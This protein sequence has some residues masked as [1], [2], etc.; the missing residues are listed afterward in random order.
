MRIPKLILLLLFIS[1]AGNAYSQL[2][3]LSQ[4]DDLSRILIEKLR[5][6][7]S[8]KIFVQTDRTFYN[9]GEKIWFKVYCLNSLSGRPVYHPKTLYIDLV[10]EKDSCAARLLLHNE[11]GST[12]GYI[13][14]P[15]SI[16]SGYYLIRGYSKKVLQSNIN[17]IFTVPVY[18]YNSFKSEE[19]KSGRNQ[20]RSPINTRPRLELYPEGGSLIAG[21]NCLIAFRAYDKEGNPAEISGY[22][23]DNRD[24]V[25]TKFQTS[26]PGL[27]KFNF[28]MWAIRKYTI[29]VKD[30]D[31]AELTYPLPSIRQSAAQISVTSENNNELTVQTALGDSIYNKNYVSYLLCVS[32]DSLCFAAAGKGMYNVAIPKKDI[33]P[34]KA[35]LLLFNEKNQLLSERNIYIEHSDPVSIDIKTDKDNYKARDQINMT[36]SVSGT[37]QHAETALLSVAV[38]SDALVNAGIY[39]PGIDDLRITT[40]D[41]PE[42]EF[43][44]DKIKNYTPDEWNLVMLTQKNSYSELWDGIT[45][46]PPADTSDDE[47][48]MKKFTGRIVNSD[49][50]PVEN[51]P[52][53]LTFNQL[54]VAMAQSTTNSKGRFQFDLPYIPDDSTLFTIRTSGPERD[55]KILV[56]DNLFPVVKTPPRLKSFASISHEDVARA[57]KRQTDSIVNGKGKELKEV[58][59]STK[60]STVRHS[61]VLTSKDLAQGVGSISNAILTIP[62]VQMK[63]GYVVIHGGTDMFHLD[64]SIEPIVV[65]NGV[66]TP[67]ER[68][69]GTGIGSPVLQLLEGIP[70]NTIDNITV[71][72]GADASIYGSQG[73]NGAIVVTTSSINQDLTKSAVEQKGVEIKVYKRTYFKTSPFPEPGYAKKNKNK[74]PLIDYQPTV[75]WNGSALTGIDGKANYS[76]Y[77]ADRTSPYTVTVTGV[78]AKGDLIYRQ[79]K[80]NQQ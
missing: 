43:S 45:H 23:T 8:E 11:T 77:A 10:N 65:I 55:L 18:V 1:A 22:V 76:F 53:S 57:I 26:Y 61:N 44:A 62:G 31:N 50:T 6:S 38:T 51:M 49:N 27:G 69:A 47:A 29:H 15:H 35:T 74:V 2:T 58:K 28:E 30:K 40:I 42:N 67:G 16:N 59:V 4:L 34:G 68:T 5:F 25:A 19:N 79:V 21:I 75:Y 54:P 70:I 37:D 60:T 12:D 66:I 14:I 41:F 78:T 64:P 13:D 7:A 63:S 24:S 52:V 20:S 9:T 72:T 39:K 48:K 73:G 17:S 71:L 36:V 33:P 3:Q 56:D 32:G 46:P 80:I